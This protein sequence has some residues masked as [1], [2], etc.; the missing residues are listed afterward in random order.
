MSQENVEIVRRA[1][2]AYRREGL[3][4]YLR[5]FDP[6]IEWTT[7]GA[8]LEQGTYRGHQGVRRYLAPIEAEFDDL[9]VEPQ[10]LIDAGEQVVSSVR[11]SGWGK[12]SGAPVALTLISVGKLR[13]GMVYRLRNYPDMAT[14]LEAAGLTE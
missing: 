12:T 7:T 4:G 13:D 8:Y 6:A 2:D 14:A 5:Y 10:K 9:R 1:L 3:D 11:I